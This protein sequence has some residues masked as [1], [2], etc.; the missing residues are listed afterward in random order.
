MQFNKNRKSHTKKK[1][2]RNGSDYITTLPNDRNGSKMANLAKKRGNLCQKRGNLGNVVWV[3][4]HYH[5]ITLHYQ[6]NKKETNEEKI[7]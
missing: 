3:R 5:Y 1:R 7:W 2:N 4:L 6:T